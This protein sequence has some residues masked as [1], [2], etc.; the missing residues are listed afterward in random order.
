V[1]AMVAHPQAAC[2]QRGNPLRG[3]EFGP[4]PV[5]QGPLEQEAHEAHLLLRGEPG[6]PARRRLGLQGLW[7]P[8]LQGIA[9]P[10]HTAGVAAEASANLMQGQRLLEERDHLAPTLFQGVGRS[11]RSHGDT[12]FPEGSIVLHY[13]CGSQ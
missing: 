6:G 7:P 13:L 5:R 10:E 4:V 9:P 11:A 3:P 1:I 8:G 12:P 2:D